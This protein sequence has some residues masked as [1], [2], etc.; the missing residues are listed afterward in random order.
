MAK[1]RILSGMRPTGQLHI[2]HYFGALVNWVALQDE[3]D[4]F[5]MVA[6]WHALTSEYKDSGKIAG[7]S[8]ENV[9]DWIA[10]GLDPN[11]STIFIQSHV[12]EHAEL[13]LI[14]SC[15]TPLGWLER[16][17]TYKDALKE[18]EAKGVDNYAFLGYPVLQ[19]ADIL[20]YKGDCVPVGQDQLAH[21]E[22]TREIVRRFNGIFGKTVFPEPQPRLTKVSLLTGL[23]GRKMSKSY[24]NGILLS[25]EEAPLRKK[26]LSMFTDPARKRRTDPG[27]PDICNVF[28]WHKIFSAA[29]RVPEIETACKGATIGCIDCKGEIA[30]RLAAFLKPIRE[31]RRE[32]LAKPKELDQIIGDGTVKAR[33]IAA[34]T[35]REV[36]DVVFKTG[37]AAAASKK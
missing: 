20:L 26:V 34:E 4:A 29:P 25:E 27:H 33:R 15:V 23:D 10:C 13:H 6:D 36:R 37:Q 2:G 5:Y 3:F 11:K 8:R 19:A 7:F 12:P 17:P 32:L 24:D 21:L 28:T 30:D 1:K 9:A 14:L 18:L 31:K 22:L 16:V 35:M